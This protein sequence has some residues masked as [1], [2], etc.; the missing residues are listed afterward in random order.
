MTAQLLGD[1]LDL[2]GRDPLHVHLGQRRHQRLLRALVALEQFRRSLR[3]AQE[4][5]AR[6]CG[7]RSSSVPTRVTSERS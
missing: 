3:R 2:P 1:R 7:T 5:P 4:R 6:S